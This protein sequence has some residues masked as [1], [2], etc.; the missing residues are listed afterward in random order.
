MADSERIIDTHIHIW[1]LENIRYGWLEGD[2]SILNQT[3]HLNQLENAHQ[4][5][6]VTGGVLVQAENHFEDTDWMLLNAER[7][8]WIQ[9]IVG[10]MPLMT[11]QQTSDAL[12]KYMKN[13]YFKGVR[14]LIHDEKDPKWL[15]QSEVIESLQMLADRNIPYDVVGVLPA[16]IETALEVA[17]KV[18]NLKMV[19][20]HL[21]QPPMAKNER[22]GTWGE[23]MSEVAKNMNFYQKISGLG[24]ATGDWK[25]WSAETVKPYVS[26]VLEHFSVDRC[27]CG[28]DWPVSRLAGEYDRTWDV[29][30]TLLDSLLDAQDLDKVLFSNA[31]NFYN[32]NLG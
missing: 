19:F 15:L 13:P 29:Y 25:N 7:T 24:T 16:H 18:P 28:G 30:K 5:A 4:E 8:D 3:H 1:D 21:N 32:L 12:D 20:D 11:P 31:N 10:W 6:G 9:G 2:T 17:R 22:F 14:H 26:F 27:F 23:L